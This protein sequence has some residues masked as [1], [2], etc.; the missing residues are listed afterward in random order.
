M[1]R[2]ENLSFSLSVQKKKK[3]EN[4]KMKITNR[5]LGVLCLKF[6]AGKMLQMAN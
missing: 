1:C 5:P 6:Y 2:C 3:A 4:R